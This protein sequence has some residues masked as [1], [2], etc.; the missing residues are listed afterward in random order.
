MTP[1][2]RE[3]VLASHNEGKIKELRELVAPLSITVHSASELQLPEPEETGAT[4]EANAALKAESAANISG[5]A[6]LADDSGLSVEALNGDPGI[7]SARWAGA[8]KDFSMAMEKVHQ[9]LVDAGEEPQ[10]AEACFVCVL[11]LA[12]PEQE[13]LMFR[14]EIHGHLTF[15]ARGKRGFGYDP[16]FVPNHAETDG[17]QS[18]A[19]VDPALKQRISHRAEAFRLFI[20]YLK[21]QAA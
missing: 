5:K 3:L 1:P 19:E 13:T 16:I 7:Y 9:A 18:F 8:Q 14:G 15:P 10:G 11:A 20:D 12:V 4:F 2:L 21:Q 17:T 6:S